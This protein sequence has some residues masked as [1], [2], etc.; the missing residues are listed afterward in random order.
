MIAARLAPVAL[1]VS[2][3]VVDRTSLLA[4]QRARDPVPGVAAPQAGGTAA[5]PIAKAP[6]DPKAKRSYALG[7]AMAT[8][9]RGAGLDLD[10]DLVAR[11]VRDA[12]LGGASLL[13]KEELKAALDSLRLV[14]QTKQEG[15]QQ[16][17]GE[18][19]AADGAAFL[20]LNKAKEGV[21]SLGSGLQYRVLTAGDGRR[22]TAQDTVLCH[23]RGTLLDGR[24]FDSSRKRNQPVT[25][26]LSR[27]IKGWSEAL[28]LMPV[29]SK[30]QLFVP[31]ELA[32]GERGASGKI[33]PNATLIFE[34]ELLSIQEAPKA[35][36]SR[37][38]DPQPGRPKEP[39][40]R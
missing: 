15:L 21:V 33:G 14:F 40:S 10:A 19:N 9:A 39:A 38:P 4:S 22:P 3:L 12:L 1:V 27:V 26:A 6:A 30:W 18:K 32:Y 24:E 5:A 25:F 34:V 20:A 7:V 11:G 29:G 17:F 13:T 31:P 2:M 8:E 35:A 28:Q 36:P 23:Y 37:P 16:Q